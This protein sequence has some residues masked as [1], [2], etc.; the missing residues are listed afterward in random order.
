[1]KNKTYENKTLKPKYEEKIK[2]INP[3]TKTP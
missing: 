2:T 3:K 1:M